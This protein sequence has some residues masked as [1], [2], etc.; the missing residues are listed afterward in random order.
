MRPSGARLPPRLPGRLLPGWRC[1]VVDRGPLEEALSA[2]RSRDEAKLAAFAA[3]PEAGACWTTLA[4]A[5]YALI[6]FNDHEAGVSW[7]VALSGDVD[8]N[9]AVAG[10]ALADT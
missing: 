6:T 2:V 9:A 3:D 7:A 5:L 4:V 8:T 1:R 10:A